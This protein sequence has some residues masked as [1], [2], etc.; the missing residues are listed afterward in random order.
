MPGEIKVFRLDE[1]DSAR[2]WVASMLPD[3]ER[4]Y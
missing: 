2:E 4:M 3:Q 1:L